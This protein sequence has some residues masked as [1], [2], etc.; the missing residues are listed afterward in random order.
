MKTLF[1]KL[2][3][4]DFQAAFSGWEFSWGGLLGNSKGEWWLIGQIFL[5]A[6]HLLRPW[7][8]A[9]PL[10]NFPSIILIKSLGLGFFLVGL[11]QA[12]QSFLDLGSSLSPFPEPK[13]GSSLVIVGAYKFCR[14]P[15]YKAL[16]FCS[17]GFCLF[18]ISL[19]HLLLLLLLAFLLR[20]K[21]IREEASLK[22]L[23]KDYFRY[24]ETTPAI[25]KKVPFLDWR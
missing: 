6:A 16:L 3:S 22:S 12:I 23:Y 1:T 20:S 10:L 21:A 19:L 9:L 18:N 25:I 2:T 14:H 17:F 13:T 4:F 11:Y 7:P 5:I 24:M 15:L 8:N